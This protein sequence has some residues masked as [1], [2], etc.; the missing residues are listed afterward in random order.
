MGINS[1]VIWGVNWPSNE[2]QV[3]LEK[4]VSRLTRTS[5][6][7]VDAALKVCV[8]VRTR[9]CSDPRE[10]RSY[11]DPRFEVRVCPWTRGSR[12]SWN[13][14]FALEWGSHFEDL[15]L[16]E[17]Y[18]AYTPSSLGHPLLTRLLLLLVLSSN[19]THQQPRRWQHH[20]HQHSQQQHVPPSLR[21]LPCALKPARPPI[22]SLCSSPDLSRPCVSPNPRLHH[23]RESFPPLAASSYASRVLPSK[24]FVSD[25]VQLTIE[26]NSGSN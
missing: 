24:S 22:T 14:T 16:N 4:R 10:T 20:H 26:P 12:F 5:R 7:R 25:D 23:Q 6:C 15:S 19:W 21:P 3:T 8:S 11:S 9:S 18:T 17:F 1:H 2:G 13:T